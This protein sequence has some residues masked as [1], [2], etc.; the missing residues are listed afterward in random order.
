MGLWGRATAHGL[1]DSHIDECTG[2]TQ[3]VLLWGPEGWES[4][5]HVEVGSVAT[6]LPYHPLLSFPK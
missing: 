3:Q 2:I 4:L 6:I 5:S 1:N